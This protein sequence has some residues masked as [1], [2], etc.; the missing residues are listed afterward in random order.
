M[1]R[2]L[3]H[4]TFVLSLLLILFASST[5]FIHAQPTAVS[6]PTLLITELMPHPTHGGE[7]VEITYWGEAPLDLSEYKIGDEETLGGGEGILRFPT[8]TTIAPGQ[9][10]LIAQDS[11]AFQLRYGF[12]PD[13]AWDEADTAVSPL[14]LRAPDLATG[15]LNLANGGDELLLLGPDNELADALSYGTSTHFFDPAIPAPLAGQSLARH[16]PPC[17]NDTAVD[18][19]ATRPTP[20]QLPDPQPCQPPLDLSG[21]TELTV[22]QIQGAGAVSPIVNQNITVTGT[23]IGQHISRNSRGTIYHT[24]FIQDE[25]DGNPATS[26]GLPIFFGRDEVALQPGDVIEVTGRVIEFF[27]LTEIS[28]RDMSWRTIGTADLPEPVELTSDHLLD[29]ESLEG[30]LITLPEAVVMGATHAGCGMAVALPDQ[31]ER[32]L[33]HTI[34]QDVSPILPVLFQTNVACTD[35]PQLKTGDIIRNLRGPLTYHFDQ[36]KIVLQDPSALE[37]IPAPWPD[38]PTVPERSGGEISVASFNLFNHFDDVD[39]T[40][41]DSEPKPT[42]VDITLKEQKIAHAIQGVLGCPT[43]IGIQEVEN[44]AL[45]LSLAEATEPLCG[46]RYEVSHL[47]SDDARGI[48]VALLS[49]PRR[50]FITDVS[51]QRACTTLDIGL[52]RGHCPAG[53]TRLFSRPPIEVK[54][55]LDNQPFVVYV[56]H[57]KSKLGGEEET[58]PER[59]AQAEHQRELVTAVL[60]ANPDT[61]VIVI[62]DFNDYADSEPMQVF[63]AEGIGQLENVLRRLPPEEQYSYIYAG[64]SQLIDGLLFTPHTA[65]YVTD[66]HIQHVNADFPASLGQDSSP[67]FLLYGHSDHD[68]PLALLSLPATATTPPTP[69]PADPELVEVEP[70][71]EPTAVSPTATPLPPTPTNPTDPADNIIRNLAL[72]ATALILL[73]TLAGLYLWRKQ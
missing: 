64:V 37:V 24:W 27:G 22:S 7:W 65:Q 49:D 50:A 42:A 55:L 51:L 43:V 66:V 13:F 9:T 5:N 40:G 34:D 16:N 53:Q 70:E 48:D 3:G 30:M 35:W 26:D 1:K 19:I 62:G 25:G 63:T 32:L 52:P 15:S 45:L 21:E 38:F 59:I 54:L 23:V 47:E 57:F 56:N 2:C 4:I 67:D 12:P 36:Y 33:R 58:T 31:S 46:F 6:N 11:A 20:G 28:D 14:L 29:L 39:N 61:H 18:W 8:G 73:G 68:L 69:P 72:F 60:S 71:P 10:M 17:D 44:E 41:L